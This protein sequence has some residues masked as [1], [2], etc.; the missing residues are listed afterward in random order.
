MKIGDKATFIVNYGIADLEVIC[1]AKES[2]AFAYGNQTA[3]VM[4]WMYD[5][6]PNRRIVDT[7][8]ASGKFEDVCIELIRDYFGE[9]AKIRLK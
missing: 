9:N 1:E 6:M 7:R 8:Y 3:T 5:G 2:G 4:R